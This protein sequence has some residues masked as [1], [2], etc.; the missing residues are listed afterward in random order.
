MEKVRGA[1]FSMLLAGSAGRCTFPEA[2]SGWTSTR[3]RCAPA[4]ILCFCRV[5]M[6]WEHH[7]RELWEIS[8]SR[9]CARGCCPLVNVAVAKVAAWSVGHIATGMGCVLVK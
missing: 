7:F 9:R 3:A 2:S 1:L 4:P 8:C 6:E 5:P